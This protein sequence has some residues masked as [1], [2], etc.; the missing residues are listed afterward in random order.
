[1]NEVK[2]KQKRLRAPQRRRQ[3]LEVATRMLAE[4]GADGLKLESLAV[5]AGVSKPV[6]YDHFPSRR[7]LVSAL[8]RSYADDLL[9]SVR[10]GLESHPDDFAAAVKTATR[11]HFDC[12]EERGLAL[13]NLYASTGGDPE[14]EQLRQGNRRRHIKL[15]ATRI[16]EITGADKRE[17]ESLAAMLVASD[18]A[19]VSQWL[20]GTLSRR[21]AEELQTATVLSAVDRLKKDHQELARRHAGKPKSSQR[22]T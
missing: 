6:V 13:K 19:A 12:V 17:A 18:E 4:R 9:E 8:I 20:S 5:E 14:L 7:D 15:W 16:G 21:R 1:M 2:G 10:Q 3:L 11:A 22:R